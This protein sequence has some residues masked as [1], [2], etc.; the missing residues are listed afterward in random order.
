MKKERVKLPYR[1]EG[2]SVSDFTFS[3]DGLPPHPQHLVVRYDD[4]I[5]D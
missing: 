3:I 2:W 1:A 4:G 5:E